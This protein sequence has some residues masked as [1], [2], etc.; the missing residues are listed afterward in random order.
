MKSKR[1]LILL[2]PLTLGVNATTLPESVAP[3]IS[4]QEVI[5]NTEPEIPQTTSDLPSGDTGISETPE[6]TVSSQNEATAVGSQPTDI[7]LPET[8]N[9]ADLVN[10]MFDRGDQE[11]TQVDEAVSAPATPTAVTQSTVPD[12]PTPPPAV[13]EFRAPTAVAQ[14]TVPDAPTPPP[15]VPKY[16]SSTKVSHAT[17]LAFGANLLRYIKPDI[18]KGSLGQ[19]SG[20]TNTE[21]AKENVSDFLVSQAQNK[22]NEVK[23]QPGN[24]TKQDVQGIQS[25]IASINADVASIKENLSLLALAIADKSGKADPALVNIDDAT[26]PS[27]GEVAIS[28]G[29]P[30]DTSQAD[31]EK[32]VENRIEHSKNESAENLVSDKYDDSKASDKLAENSTSVSDENKNVSES[33]T[34]SESAAKEKP[35]IKTSENLT[36]DTTSKMEEARSEQEKSGSEVATHSDASSKTEIAD[37]SVEKTG[38]SELSLILQELKKVNDKVNNLDDKVDNLK[39]DAE[40]T[41]KSTD[42]EIKKKNN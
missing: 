11:P 28:E 36:S 13:P 20:A 17:P 42:D 32:A 35:V 6:Q 41:G 10:R 24:L 34:V 31:Q 4:G 9:E 5:P 27:D 8:G 16:S 33:A 14:S 1:L 21:I 19:I 15:A 40:K 39:R 30:S 29:V 26:A 25:N 37:K 3:S 38:S 18:V 22:I 12:A 23:M 7:P 2:A